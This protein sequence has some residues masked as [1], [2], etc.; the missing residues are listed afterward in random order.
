[1]T[2]LPCLISLLFLGVFAQAA[3]L[4]PVIQ[5]RH[6]GARL[7]GLALPE[8]LRKDLRSGLANRL[9]LRVTLLDGT[10]EHASANVGIALK[11]D[12]WD[13]RFRGELTIN[14]VAQ[15]VPE[16]RTV[17]E[18]WAWLTDLSLVPLF[19]K[20]A[21]A[22]ALTMQ[23][24]VLLN[25]I[26]RERMEQIREWVKE[27]SRFVPL[28]GAPGAAAESASNSVFN[29]IFERY[30]ADRETAAQWRENVIS[31]PFNVSAR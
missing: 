19:E 14:E 11:Y 21:A 28:E 13:E 1:V 20:P 9:L 30:A 10:R 15:S 23:A 22:P 12:L 24:D 6:I 5:E 18:A 31:V 16:L 3:D 25:P 4:T 17:E 2:R 8:S 7:R 29:R 26:E 27:N